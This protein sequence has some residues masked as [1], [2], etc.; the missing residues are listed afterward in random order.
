MIDKLPENA[1]PLKPHEPEVLMLIRCKRIA[2]T[3]GYVLL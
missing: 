2:M 1:S 3:Y